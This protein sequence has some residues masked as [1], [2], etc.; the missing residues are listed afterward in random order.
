MSNKKIGIVVG[1]ARK[2]GF[3]KT[4]AD[5]LASSLAAQ[6]DVHF[7]QIDDLALFN[8]D[9]D[10][11]NTVPDAWTRFRSEVKEMDAYVFVTPEYNRSFTPLLK[12]ALD[13][14]SRP[15]GQS[16][17]SGKPAAIVSVSP[18]AIG[19]FGA[20]NHLRQVF[21]SLNLYTMQQPEAY[22][23]KITAS[24][25]DDGKLNERTASFLGSIADSFTAWI[26]KF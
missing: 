15:F 17:W 24:L 10:E 26:A 7:I 3:S 22:L 16:G 11:E 4:V 25:D 5:A 6:H 21:S 14:A 1:S 20:N 12:N 13:I 23:G 8:Q 19:G 9:Y 2:G 18:G